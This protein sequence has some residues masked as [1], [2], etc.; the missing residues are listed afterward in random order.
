MSKRS[1]VKE[2]WLD[3]VDAWDR[4]VERIGHWWHT[5]TKR[6]HPPKRK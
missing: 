4:L 3:M 2:K 6:G 1:A 5:L